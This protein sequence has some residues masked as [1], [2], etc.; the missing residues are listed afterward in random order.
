MYK[1]LSKP[2]FPLL[3]RLIMLALFLLM[4]VGLTL[5][6]SSPSMAQMEPR[7]RI[8]RG[9]T[10]LPLP[11]F[12]SLKSDKTNLRTGPGVQYPI[13]WV[14]MRKGLPILITAEYGAWRQIRDW[15]GTKG[16]IRGDLLSGKRRAQITG[17]TRTLYA[18]PD[19]KSTPVLKAEPQVIG[20][21]RECSNLWCHV[22]ILGKS[23]WL[24]QATIWGTFEQE[25]VKR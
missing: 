6:L 2:P 16:W 1:A 23:A 5:A 9:D 13:Q 18:K 24:P 3:V 17:K 11:R 25:D 7:E 12:V 20:D 4:V 19:I 8:A 21:I 10:G 22:I 15:E 14:Y